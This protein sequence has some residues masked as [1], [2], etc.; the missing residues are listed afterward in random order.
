MLFLLA[1]LLACRNLVARALSGPHCGLDFRHVGAIGFGVFKQV[2]VQIE[3][4]V[5]RR[6][7]H[8]GL[9]ALRRPAQ[10]GDE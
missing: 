3:C 7:T 2:A 8:D 4:H 1:F 10:V 9:Q 6:M 5:D